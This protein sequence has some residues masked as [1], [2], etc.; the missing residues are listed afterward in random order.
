MFSSIFGSQ[1]VKTKRAESLFVNS[2][3]ASDLFYLRLEPNDFERT[4]RY[5]PTAEQ[6]VFPN[7]REYRDFV[8][9]I[10]LSGYQ[11]QQQQNAKCLKGSR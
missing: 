8:S 11:Q 3:K 5:V 2:H 6:D 10:R 9:K 1:F 4:H 7:Y